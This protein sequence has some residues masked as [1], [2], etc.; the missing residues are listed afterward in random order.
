M[1]APAAGWYPDPQNAANLRWWDGN[2]WTD[3]IQPSQTMP[4]P[5][6]WSAP[7]AQ[8]APAWAGAPAGNLPSAQADTGLDVYYRERFAQFD[9][10]GSTASWNWAA[11]LFGAF[12]Y[13][14][15]GLWAKALL[16]IF[17][18]FLSG[19][20]LGIPLWIYGGVMGNYDYYLL[21][22]KQQ[23]LW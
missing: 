21:R 19:G 17:V 23:Q 22:R 10:N 12:W 13:F 2:T 5:A 9:R 14:S 8:P 7:V 4:A 11:F 1:T 18:A 3:T 6:P 15:K 20:F 16:I